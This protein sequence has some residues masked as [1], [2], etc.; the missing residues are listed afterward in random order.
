[1]K[2][3][4]NLNKDGP[5]YNSQRSIESMTS[6]IIA[7]LDKII[8]EISKDF[9]LG[10][11]IGEISKSIGDT[12]S[13]SKSQVATIVIFNL[14]ESASLSV[15]HSHDE[16][17][18]KILLHERICRS[19]AK[20]FNACVIKNVDDGIL[21]V[22]DHPL[23][24]CLTAINVKEVSN[25]MKISTK[26]ALALGLIETAKVNNKIEVFGTTVDRCSHIGRCV[27]ENQILIDKGLHDSVVTFLKNYEDIVISSSMSAILKGHGRI[28]LYEISSNNFKLRNCLNTPIFINEEGRLRTEENVALIQNAKSEIIKVGTGLNEFTS[29]FFSKNPAEFKNHVRELLRKGINFK[30]L[31]V[32]PEWIITKIRCEHEEDKKYFMEIPNNLNKLKEVQN[33]FV[34][35]KLPGSFEIF[36]YKNMPLFHAICIDATNEEGRMIISNY[37]PGIEKSSCPVLHFSK[38]SNPVMFNT[39]LLSIN[40]ILKTANGWKTVAE[41]ELTSMK[42]Y[43]NEVL[44]EVTKLKSI[45]YKEL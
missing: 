35:E 30:C 31:A 9:E 16:V 4:E 40:N 2:L 45:N 44:E 38:I 5:Q 8:T 22:F 21:V 29:C 25:K 18:E 23:N 13:K 1:M 43:L 24:A 11:K 15:Q 3:I 26:A 42:L 33:E 12:G 32:D 39:Y 10:K 37:L 20:K 17:M 6:S 36:V 19:I 14:S 28:E 27:F 7:H 34:E 41:D